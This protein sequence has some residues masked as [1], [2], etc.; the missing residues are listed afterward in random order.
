[1][2]DT[3]KPKKRQMTPEARERMLANLKKGREAKAR[4]LAEAKKKKEMEKG[5]INDD[6]IVNGNTEANGLKTSNLSND[7]R[8][9]ERND[10]LGGEPAKPLAPKSLTCDGCKKVFK[11]S[12][13]KSKHIKKCKALNPPVPT[14]VPTPEPIHVPDPEPI[15]QPIRKQRKKQRV[16]IVE[17]ESESSSSE[18]EELVIHKKRRK[19]KNIVINDAPTPTP[20]QNLPVAPQLSQQEI[21]LRKEQQRIMMM[22]RS[23]GN[24]ML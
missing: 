5:Q 22:A 12:S 9:D 21:A 11:H 6:T 13:S 14:P 17:S 15:P 7:E 19:R 3:E 4:K 10:T 8:N 23:M 24:V 1:M 18:E 16:T 2:S 20:K